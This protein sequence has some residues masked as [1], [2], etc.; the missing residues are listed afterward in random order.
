MINRK[1]LPPNPVLMTIGMWVLGII[2]R[3]HK[4]EFHYDYDRKSI[5]NQATVLLASQKWRGISMWVKMSTA[6]RK[7][8]WML[9]PGFRCCKLQEKRWQWIFGINADFCRVIREFCL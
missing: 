2:N 3:A 9:W 5:K 1:I 7:K 6:I 4:V 8:I